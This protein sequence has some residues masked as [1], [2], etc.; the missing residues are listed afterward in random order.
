MWNTA[1]V[2]THASV[3]LFIVWFIHLD[4]RTNSDKSIFI[5]FS[6]KRSYLLFYFSQPEYP[7]RWCIWMSHWKM[8]RILL[9]SL[10]ICTDHGII[11]FNLNLAWARY[12]FL[13]PMMTHRIVNHGFLNEQRN[14]ILLRWVATD[15]TSSED[16]YA[17]YAS[18][19]KL[20]RA[21]N[22]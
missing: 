12:I 2:S 17:Y 15:G 7:S 10:H 19:C 18:V 14:E 4:L 20:S 5:V 1:N 11:A 9:Q 13:G 3:A 21:L 16:A 6:G 8:L 22:F